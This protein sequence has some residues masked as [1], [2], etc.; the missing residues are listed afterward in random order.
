[1][2]RNPIVSAGEIKFAKWYR[3]ELKDNLLP[4]DD[5]LSPKH[6]ILFEIKDIEFPRSHFAKGYMRINK[7]SLQRH[8]AI[9]N[10]Y[11]EIY[12]VLTF[13][14]GTMLVSDIDSV[15]KTMEPDIFNMTSD[16]MT[17]VIHLDGFK[18]INALREIIK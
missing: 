4:D 9:K 8:Q 2:S 13:S 18:D 5:W 1:M 6:N 16:R 11:K 7:V 15:M 3:K 10:K 12:I 14:D 17:T